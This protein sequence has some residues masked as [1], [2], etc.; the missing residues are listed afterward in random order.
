MFE[1]LSDN[2]IVSGIN[3]SEFDKTVLE[4]A[5]IAE[6]LQ[7]L[8]SRAEVTMLNA[9]D[10]YHS[11]SANRLF[12]SFDAFKTNFDV[13]VANVKTYEFDLAKVKTNFIS[14]DRQSR[15][16]LNINGKEGK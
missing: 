7:K 11:E 14:I 2:N 15:E 12:D 3:F 16:H 10:C 13:V 9:E 1:S 6:E 8:F 4:I 5:E